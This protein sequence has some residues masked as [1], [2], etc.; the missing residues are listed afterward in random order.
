MA[1]AG[2]MKLFMKKLI[3]RLNTGNGKYVFKLVNLSSYKVWYKKK[4]TLYI[5]QKTPCFVVFR[6]ELEKAIIIIDFSTFNLSKC[7]ISCKKN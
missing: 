2:N 4:K 7:N 6:L 3:F 1:N 5:A